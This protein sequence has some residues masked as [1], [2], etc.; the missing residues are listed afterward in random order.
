MYSLDLVGLHPANNSKLY[1]LDPAFR[2]YTCIILVFGCYDRRHDTYREKRAEYLQYV[3]CA[4]Y[5][6]HA[7]HSSRQWNW[8]VQVQIF[9]HE[10]RVE[11]ERKKGT[12]VRLCSVCAWSRRRLAL[13]GSE[14]Y[15]GIGLVNQTVKKTFPFFVRTTEATSWAIN[16]L[17]WR[18]CTDDFSRI[19]RAYSSF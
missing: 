18:R 6:V 11:E 14:S 9:W 3:Q 5:Q 15:F 16:S 12:Q 2:K 4:L 17:L 13:C 1:L 10:L 8:N 7:R 19:T